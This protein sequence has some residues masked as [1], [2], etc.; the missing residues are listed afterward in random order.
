[1]DDLPIVGTSKAD[2]LQF[3]NDLQQT[4]PTK[5][6]GELEY[7]LGLEV[8]RNRSIGTLSVS[9]CK[10]VDNILHKYDMMTCSP[11][12]TPLTVP[13]HLSTSDSPS[14]NEEESFM[15]SIPYRHIL[16]SL[17]YLVS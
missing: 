8:N 4:F 3:V 1:M 5:H 6:L 11:V 12:A 7:F 9:Q 16:G 14:T 2:I 13:C 15:Q 17:R 10:L